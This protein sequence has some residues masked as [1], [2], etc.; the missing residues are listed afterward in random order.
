ML[1]DAVGQRLRLEIENKVGGGGHRSL[2]VYCP[3]WIVNTSQYSI[4]LREDGAL[5]LP[6]GTVTPKL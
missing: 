4:R 6:A 1:T 2:V 3:Y 5:Y